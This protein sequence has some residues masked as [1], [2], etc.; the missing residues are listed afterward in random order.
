MSLEDTGLANRG[1]D[2]GLSSFHVVF[3]TKAVLTDLWLGAL[4]QFPQC[5]HGAQATKHKALR[6][7]ILVVVQL[8]SVY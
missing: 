7:G 5:T 6:L 3:A 4:V 8:L 1:L 2:G